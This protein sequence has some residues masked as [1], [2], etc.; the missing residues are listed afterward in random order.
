VRIVWRPGTWL[1]SWR[2]REGLVMEAPFETE[3][4][5]LA[6]HKQLSRYSRLTAMVQVVE[7]VENSIEA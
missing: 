4:A 1:L 2:R 5:M 6:F 7:A 3:D